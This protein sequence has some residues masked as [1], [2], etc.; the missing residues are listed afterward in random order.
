[1]REGERLSKTR[2][3]NIVLA[4]AMYA[5]M[6]MPLLTQ[7]RNHV[8]LQLISVLNIN[9]ERLNPSDLDEPAISIS[10]RQISGGIL[11]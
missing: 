9:S 5:L 1:M 7:T 4:E 2:L 6:A 11:S 3:N 8:D 10:M